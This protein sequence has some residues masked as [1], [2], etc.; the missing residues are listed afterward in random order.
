MLYYCLEDKVEELVQITIQFSGETTVTGNLSVLV[1]DPQF[2]YLASFRCDEES[3][4]NLPYPVGDT[5]SVW[6]AIANENVKEL[7]GP[8]PFEKNCKLTIKNYYIHFAAR[9]VVNTAE[10]VKIEELTE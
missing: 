10:I 7:L 9:D 8:D 3:A 5:R 2:A 6:F 4:K 1:N